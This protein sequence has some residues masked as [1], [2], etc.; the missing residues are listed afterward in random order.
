MCAT[1]ARCLC[2]QV[3]LEHNHNLFPTV[4]W[5]AVRLVSSTCLLIQ[6]VSG[7]NHD[8]RG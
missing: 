3:G 4:A 2:N 7:I 5:A 8:C 1:Q 6:V